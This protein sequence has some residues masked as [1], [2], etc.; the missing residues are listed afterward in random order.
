MQITPSRSLLLHLLQREEGGEVWEAEGVGKGILNKQEGGGEDEGKLQG[1]TLRQRE[2]V[3]QE[4]EDEDEAE[5]KVT[6]SI[7]VKDQEEGHPNNLEL[8][9]QHQPHP[10]R[11]HDPKWYKQS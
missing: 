7:R 11:P 1:M 8:D 3:L 2:V 4:G 6:V 10:L 5:E 9:L